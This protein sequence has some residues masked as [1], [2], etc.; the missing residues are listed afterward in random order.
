MWKMALALLSVSLLLTGCGPEK[1][2]YP[3]QMLLNECET[4]PPKN[5]RGDKAAKYLIK[6]LRNQNENACEQIHAYN[7]GII[8][9]CEKHGC[10]V[11]GGGR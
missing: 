5:V 2:I 11:L 8:A 1:Y 10:E 6:R 9:F 4:I 7:L 3:P